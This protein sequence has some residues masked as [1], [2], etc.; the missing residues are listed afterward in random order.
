[1]LT[2]MVARGQ[3]GPGTTDQGPGTRDQGPGAGD[4]NQG[5]AVATN[6][7]T[8]FAFEPNDLQLC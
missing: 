6:E 5:L 3:G 4:Q 1:M 7:R 8:E 2:S